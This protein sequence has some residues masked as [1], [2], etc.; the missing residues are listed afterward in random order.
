MKKIFSFMITLLLCLSI[1]SVSA[2][3][4][5]IPSGS[6]ICAISSNQASSYTKTVYGKY[7]YFGGHNDPDSSHKLTVCSQFFDASSNEFLYDEKIAVDP[8]FE[9]QGRKT[10]EFPVANAWRVQLKPYASYSNGCSGQG[11]IFRDQQV[12]EP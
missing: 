11:Y 10:R 1:I 3:A 12:E 5:S 2:Y 4:L 8:G 7:K 6:A 9:F